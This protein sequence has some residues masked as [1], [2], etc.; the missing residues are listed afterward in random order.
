MIL[1]YPSANSYKIDPE[2]VSKYV[3]LVE[4]DASEKELKEI[5]SLFSNATGIPI[6]PNLDL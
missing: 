2:H 1:F 5:L 6:M 4:V 3:T